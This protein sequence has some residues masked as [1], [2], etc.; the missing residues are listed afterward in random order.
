MIRSMNLTEY[1]KT[2]N[3]R[4]IGTTPGQKV[5]VLGTIRT[6]IVTG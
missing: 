2:D 5:G 4:T 1:F 6:T 3:I